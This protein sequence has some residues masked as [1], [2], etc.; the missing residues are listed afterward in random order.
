[1]S[2]HIFLFGDKNNFIQGSKLTNMFDFRSEN[3]QIND[4]TI[5][6]VLR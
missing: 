4:N 6:L 2:I 5:W 1:M 3:Y